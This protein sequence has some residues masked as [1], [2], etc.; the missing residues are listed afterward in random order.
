[1]MGPVVMMRKRKNVREEQARLMVDRELESIW[2]SGKRGEGKNGEKEKSQKSS[3]RAG[4]PRDMFGRR[5]MIVN[6]IMGRVR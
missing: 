3:G 1:M 4:D 5:K 6:A 2:M